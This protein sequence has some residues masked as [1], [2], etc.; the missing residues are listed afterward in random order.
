[1]PTTWEPITIVRVYGKQYGKRELTAAFNFYLFFSTNKVL[2][3]F[4]IYKES[5]HTQYKCM[6][7]DNFCSKFVTLISLVQYI[8][9]FDYRA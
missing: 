5:F 9:K 2:T 4:T 6:E 3:Y 7:S 8:R 1:M